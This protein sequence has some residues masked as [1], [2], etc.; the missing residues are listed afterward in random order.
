MYGG[1]QVSQEN[2]KATAK[3][4]IYDKAKTMTAQN[5]LSKMKNQTDTTKYKS[6]GEIKNATTNKANV[7]QTTQLCK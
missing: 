4:K 1:P 2:Q 6:C 5:N 7:R 3:Q